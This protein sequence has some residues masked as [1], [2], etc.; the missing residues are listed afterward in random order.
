MTASAQ[1]WLTGGGTA[2]VAAAMTYVI[3]ACIA[4]RV[5][6]LPQRSPLGMV[7][8]PTT[9][10][11][12]L[13]GGEHQL[14]ERLRS[15]CEQSYPELQM[16]FGVRDPDDP[17]LEAVRRLRREFPRVDL[18]VVVNPVQHGRAPRSA[19]CST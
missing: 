19:I 4:L 12:P 3:I 5:R 17:G 18:E 9:V 10:L 8:P 15:F 16:I 7:P 14:Y 1:L 6:R 11:K 13:C 2:L